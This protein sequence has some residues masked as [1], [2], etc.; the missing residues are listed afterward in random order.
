MLICY[1]LV[2]TPVQFIYHLLRP[3]PRPLGGFPI[4]L[5]LAAPGIRLARPLETV[6]RVERRAAAAAAPRGVKPGGPNGR[7]VPPEAAFGATRW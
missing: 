5:G 1:E 3:R 7:L 6:L 4:L 2:N